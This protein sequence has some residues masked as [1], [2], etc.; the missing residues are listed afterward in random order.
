M[1]LV[2][3]LGGARS[4]KSALAVALAQASRL[5]V[6][7]LA[8][9][10]A[11]DEEMSERIARHRADRPAEWTTIE[12]PLELAGAID[13]VGADSCLVLDCLSLW[14]ANMLER[15]AD[16]GLIEERAREAAA[17]VAARSR[18]SIAVSNEVGLGIVPVTELGRRYRDV[19]GR[20]NMLWAEAASGSA[21]VVAG[22]VLNLESADS[23]LGRLDG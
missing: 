4:G 10:E 16:E 14:V 15:G 22:R 18:L 1:S 5:P 7:F 3:L 21:L 13:A 2:L 17:R 12:E 11:R 19:L 8:T 23:W 6:S 9:A 20:V